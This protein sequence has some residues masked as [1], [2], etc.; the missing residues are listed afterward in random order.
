MMIIGGIGYL[1]AFLKRYQWSA[2][3]FNFVLAAFTYQWSLLVQGKDPRTD[4]SEVDRE[5]Q[6]FIPRPYRI[7]QIEINR[8]WSVDPLLKD[9]FLKIKIPKMVK[10]RQ[11]LMEQCRIGNHLN[12]LS[13]VSIWQRYLKLNF[14]Q[15]LV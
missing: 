4:C 8:F 12:L 3:S 7:T 11:F 9:L 10:F 14:Q 15:L 6:N 2:F 1:I 5:F 13:F